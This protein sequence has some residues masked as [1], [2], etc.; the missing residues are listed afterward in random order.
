MSTYTSFLM[1]FTGHFGFIS[2]LFHLLSTFIT[3]SYV[4]THIR[5]II[6]FLNNILKD[7]FFFFKQKTAYEMRISDWSSDVCSSD[8]EPGVE[9]LQRAVGLEP[10]RHEAEQAHDAGHRCGAQGGR[11]RHALIRLAGALGEQPG[12]YDQR[13]RAAAAEGEPE[14][15]AGQEPAIARC[16]EGTAEH[17]PERPHEVAERGGGHPEPR[18]GGHGQAG[19]TGDRTSTRLNSSH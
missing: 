9:E 3:I 6:I 2:T 7:Y 11:P 1:R 18:V 17:E 8:L 14:H 19:P 5:C 12:G 10:R 16:G 15:H 13:A 4:G